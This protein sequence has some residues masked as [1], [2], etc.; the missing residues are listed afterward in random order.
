MFANE[1]SA[2]GYDW[3]AFH[4]LL[5]NVVQTSPRRWLAPGFKENRCLEGWSVCFVAWR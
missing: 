4:N 3:D 1:V 5:E 2:L